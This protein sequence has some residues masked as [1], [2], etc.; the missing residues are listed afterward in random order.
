MANPTNNHFQQLSCPLGFWIVMLRVLVGPIP[1]P[2]LP[3]GEISGFIK[4][5]HR[6]E[7]AKQCQ[8]PSCTNRLLLPM[9]HRSG[10][11]RAGFTGGR[12][13]Q[14]KP[15]DFR[16][17]LQVPDTAPGCPTPKIRSVK[18]GRR[19]LESRG[20]MEKILSVEIFSN[21]AAFNKTAEASSEAEAC[22]PG[23]LPPCAYAR[24][25]GA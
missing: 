25:G 12:G 10:A 13:A 20:Q 24:K 6:T 19:T 14:N 8:K 4:L 22:G 23:E 16:F 7:K 18:Q 11:T 17:L 2:L 3:H 1:Q 5:I 15:P 21:F 9:A